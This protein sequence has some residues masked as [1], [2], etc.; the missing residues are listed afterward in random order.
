LQTRPYERVIKGSPGYGRSR[1]Y[2]HVR[3]E[4]LQLEGLAW[5]GA[6]GGVKGSAIS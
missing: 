6:G 2:G 5:H 1:K 3:H 4:G